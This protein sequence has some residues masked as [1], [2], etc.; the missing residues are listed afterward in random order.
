MRRR[1]WRLWCQ[2]ARRSLSV[3]PMTLLLWRVNELQVPVAEYLLALFSSFFSRVFK[4]NLLLEIVYSVDTKNLEVIESQYKRQR[5][6]KSAAL[7]QSV[8]IVDVRDLRSSL[9]NLLHSTGFALRP[10]TLTIGDYILSPS[11]CIERKVLPLNHFQYPRS[12]LISSL[13]CVYNL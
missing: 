4:I 7:E 8:V 11:I 13:R 9:P 2:R 6:A 5:T 3:F 10:V 1:Q 12:L